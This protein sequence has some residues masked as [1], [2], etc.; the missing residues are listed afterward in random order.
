MRA[1]SH[2]PTRGEGSALNPHIS[3][4]P[5][6]Y[7]RTSKLFRS[8]WYTGEFANSHTKAHKLAT[9]LDLLDHELGCLRVSAV[10]SSS[11]ERC[12][13]ARAEFHTTCIT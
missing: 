7:P 4:I 5:P 3:P 13:W 1:R 12:A 8:A 6:W 9:G 11:V 2:D 10:M